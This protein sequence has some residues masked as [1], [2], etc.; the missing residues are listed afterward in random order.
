MLVRRRPAERKG[1]APG[2]LGTAFKE[3]GRWRG[4]LVGFDEISPR[5]F[6][7]GLIASS[8]TATASFDNKELVS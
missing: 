1:S 5:A 6:V 3:G 8:I 7:E 4:S 2:C